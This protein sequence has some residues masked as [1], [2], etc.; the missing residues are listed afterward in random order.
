MC[1]TSDKLLLVSATEQWK[2][3]C[4]CVELSPFRFPR[5]NFHV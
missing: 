4:S 3:E 5:K 1:Y 2:Q